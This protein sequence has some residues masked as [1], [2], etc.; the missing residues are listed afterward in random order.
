MPASEAIPSS[1]ADILLAVA[2]RADARAD[3]ALTAGAAP[4]KPA[5]PSILAGIKAVGG[6]A[7]RVVVS[8]AESITAE[9]VETVA[10]WIIQAVVGAATTA[11]I[12]RAAGNAD[13][14]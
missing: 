9:E 13:R 11:A 12:E 14:G 1:A 7:A 5:P 10:K 2:G 3:A 8:V 6:L 4:A